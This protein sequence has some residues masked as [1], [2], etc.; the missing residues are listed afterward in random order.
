VLPQ[1]GLG[2]LK[3]KQCKH[4]S[5]LLVEFL[6]GKKKTNLLLVGTTSGNRDGEAYVHFKDAEFLSP[7]SVEHRHCYLFGREGHTSLVGIP[8]EAQENLPVSCKSCLPVRG[9]FLSG[10]IL[11]VA[12]FASV[13]IGDPLVIIV[14]M[15]SSA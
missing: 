15:L 2:T 7:L 3:N 11:A 6:V 5:L 12:V 8:M 9:I 4:R 1:S 13:G 10:N 14:K